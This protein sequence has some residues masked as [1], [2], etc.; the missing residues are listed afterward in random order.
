MDFDSLLTVLIIGIAVWLFV[1]EKL[2][3]DVV[4]A[5]VLS[6]LVLLSLVTPQEGLE[7]F[8]SAATLTVAA[9]FV[10]SA[11]L[12][13]TGVL[14][15][16]A[17]LF[18]RIS[19]WPWLLLIMMMIVVA[20]V[21][22]F[23]NNTAAVAI[24]LPLVIATARL[25][26]IAPSKLLI[27]LSYAGQFGGVCTL[28]GT[29]T[30]ILI[31]GIA[32]QQGV[33]PFTMFELGQVGL[34]LC[35][36]GTVFIMLF[37]RWLLPN[38]PDRSLPDSYGIGDYV[39]DLRVRTGSPLIGKSLREARFGDNEG[40]QVIE[41]LRDEHRLWSRRCDS[42]RA[43]DVIRVAAPVEKLESLRSRPGLEMDADF[44]VS[45]N[46]K[47][48][49]DVQLIE[50]LIAPHSRLHGSRLGALANELPPQVRIVAVRHRGQ[51]L[52]GAALDESLLASGDAL[53]LLAPSDHVDQVRS[54]PD[55]LVLNEKSA[56][57]KS[58]LRAIIAVTVMFSVVLVAAMSWAPIAI[59]SITG[60]AVLV[61]TGC[62][63]REQAYRAIEWPVIVLLATLI[64]LGTALS[65]HGLADA[66]ALH[67]ISW[68]GAFGPVAV[69][70][71]LYLLAA[72]LTELMSNNATAVLLAPIAI[73]TAATMQV[74]PMPF[75]VAVTIAASTSFATPV[76]YQTNMMV[77]QA[78]SY[79]FS[80]FMRIGI[81]LNIIFF[82][83]SIWLIPKFWPF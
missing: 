16:I 50:A 32:E 58:R 45:G 51:V 34:P 30:N 18:V 41:L 31:S 59:A 22:A 68:F 3:I 82:A 67:A 23:I 70:A 74:S 73:S 78:G 27:P 37:S 17:R 81:P 20:A 1:T 57:R 53:L 77:Y 24:F 61:A 83:I 5:G 79:K 25:R 10:L 52:R 75:L 11:G 19:H 72:V 69:L 35:I 56:G 6:A 66:A 42:I 44:L 76:G 80:D 15:R 40:V 47:A 26:K 21:S 12:R 55:L 54:I 71:G 46:R 4:G 38:H 14:D 65:K 49:Q 8:A 64:P 2:P 33:R 9:M 60:A 63:K 28:I 7:G 62:L 29:S 39:A 13:E 43:G 48:E 36:A